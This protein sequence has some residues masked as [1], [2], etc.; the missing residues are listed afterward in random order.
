MNP[1]KWLNAAAAAITAAL[2]PASDRLNLQE[3]MPGV[4]TAAEVRARMGPP[5]AEYRNDNGS[6]TWEFNRSPAW[7]PGPAVASKCAAKAL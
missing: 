4:S 2:L 7:S 1:S 6:I 5:A 3:L